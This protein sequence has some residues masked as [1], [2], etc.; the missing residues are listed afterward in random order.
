MKPKDAAFARRLFYWS[1][2]AHNHG[3]SGGIFSITIPHSTDN[4]SRTA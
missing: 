4:Q 3:L 2:H 1:M